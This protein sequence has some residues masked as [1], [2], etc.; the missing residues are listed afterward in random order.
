MPVKNGKY[1]PDVKLDKQTTDELSGGRKDLN[2]EKLGHPKRDALWTWD[3]REGG[4]GKASRK[5]YK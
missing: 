3:K 4:G 2:W 1:S 5:A